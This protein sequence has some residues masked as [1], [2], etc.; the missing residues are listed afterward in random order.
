MGE[1]NN[2]DEPTEKNADADEGDEEGSDKDEDAEKG[3]ESADGE[4][5][6]EIGEELV[7]NGDRSSNRDT[8]GGEGLCGEG[9]CG[10]GERSTEE[11][12]RGEGLL[13]SEGRRP[14]EENEEE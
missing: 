2:V 14:D 12:V 10:E 6:T 7:G 8:E 13:M 11:E 4:E 5:N 3:E 9:L 1:F